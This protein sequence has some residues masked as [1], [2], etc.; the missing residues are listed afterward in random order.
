MTTPRTPASANLT[1][2]AAPMPREAPVIRATFSVRLIIVMVSRESR[3][4]ASVADCACGGQI[5]LDVQAMSRFFTRKEV[6][7][8]DGDHREGRRKDQHIAEAV[9]RNEM[10]KHLRRQGAYSPSCSHH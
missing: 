10:R 2:V 3:I 4:E 1:A 5:S 6:R 7:Q 8:D 9:C